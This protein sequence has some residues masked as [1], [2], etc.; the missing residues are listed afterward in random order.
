MALFT[1][2]EGTLWFSWSLVVWGGLQGVFTDGKANI[3]VLVFT[4]N[5]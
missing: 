3:R 5:F 4:G 1:R 2:S